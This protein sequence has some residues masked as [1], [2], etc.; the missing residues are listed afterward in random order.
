MVD[1][2]SRVFDGREHGWQWWAPLCQYH[3]DVFPSCHTTPWEGARSRAPESFKKIAQQKSG[4]VLNQYHTDVFRPVF[5]CSLWW[6]VIH[7]S[8][9]V[10]LEQ[11]LHWW[12]SLTKETKRQ[13]KSHLIFWV[14]NTQGDKNTVSGC[15]E[16]LEINLFKYLG[17]IYFAITLVSQFASKDDLFQEKRKE[18][19][20]QICH[21]FLLFSCLRGFS[22]SLSGQGSD[23]TFIFSE[24]KSC[25]VIN[26]EE[27]F[28]RHLF[29][30]GIFTQKEEKFNIS[31]LMHFGD[32][33]V[34]TWFCKF[35]KSCVFYR[36]QFCCNFLA[37]L[38][39]ICWVDIVCEIS[40]YEIKCPIRGICLSTTGRGELNFSKL[41]ICSTSVERTANCKL[42]QVM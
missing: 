42:F 30:L 10:S 36:S 9:I 15:R 38:S 8:Q 12:Q 4:Q 22:I 41:A 28:F 31:I 25:H 1:G 34:L 29:H 37:S 13:R 23:L 3:T 19:F 20:H 33:S 17:G 24:E 14:T 27:N 21:H 6:L 39:C 35:S 16:D 11:R 18:C 26:S 2:V 40:S 32:K 5:W 7:Q